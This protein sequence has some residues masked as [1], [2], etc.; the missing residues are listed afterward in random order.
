MEYY[1][2]ETKWY[3]VVSR[4][5]GRYEDPSPYMFPW[6][7]AASAGPRW[8]RHC[9]YPPAVMPR[10][11]TRPQV[12]SLLCL[13]ERSD[14]SIV[15]SSG[16]KWI[17]NGVFPQ[18]LHFSR[19]IRTLVQLALTNFMGNGICECGREVSVIAS[20]WTVTSALSIFRRC[21]CNLL[22]C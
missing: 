14:G 9:P 1:S 4:R 16:L 12:R 2:N 19:G 6:P 18:L 8:S 3:S 13:L 15:L 22:E 21:H 20:M 7:T 5:S 11:C 17:G 10:K